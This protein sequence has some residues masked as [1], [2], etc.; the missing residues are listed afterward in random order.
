MV[1]MP[2]A[3]KFFKQEWHTDPRLVRLGP[4][5]RDFLSACIKFAD[6]DANLDYDM[7]AF[8]NIVKFN[9]QPSTGDDLRRMGQTLI[10]AGFF[11]PYEVD[12][13]EYVSIPEVLVM[14]SSI[15]QK[16]NKLTKWRNPTV[17]NPEGV[18][19][20]EYMRK[21]PRTKP[22]TKADKDVAPRTSEEAVRQQRP[23]P[24]SRAVVASESN[25]AAVALRTGSRGPEPRHD[26]QRDEP[27]V[28]R[29]LD[30]RDE[31]AVFTS[32]QERRS[33]TVAKKGQKA[34]KPKPGVRLTKGTPRKAPSEARTATKPVK[35]R[36]R[37]GNSIR[38]GQ[39]G[40]EGVRKLVKEVTTKTAVDESPKHTSF[41]EGVGSFFKAW[42]DMNQASDDKMKI[43]LL[44]KLMKDFPERCKPGSKARDLYDE[45]TT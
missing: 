4:E 1:F 28:P 31:A 17:A 16:P 35:P 43:Q 27:D 19:I 24:R 26:H 36:I 20:P 13:W 37:R 6:P 33:Q 14:N 41:V 39:L 32:A 2:G 8:A 12:G 38:G 30:A 23:R 44:K 22:T 5:V 25:L 11:F 40:S 9:E 29:E 3:G 45:L 18:S 15:Y 42:M 7:D 10:E 21:K 34:R